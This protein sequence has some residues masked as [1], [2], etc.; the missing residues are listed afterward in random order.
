[1]KNIKSILKIDDRL[2]II[3]GFII[4]FVLL[5][6]FSK[7]DNSYI[8]ESNLYISEI[9][10]KNTFTLEDDLEEYS[11][12]IEIH[13]GYKKKINLLGYHLS[14]S[15]FETNKWSFPEII[16]EPG[17]YLIVYASGKNKCDIEKR[18][19]HTNFKLS[20]KG[21]T[22]TLTDKSGNIINKFMYP[23]LA[24]DLAYGF[25]KNKYTLLDKPSPGKENTAEFTY[26]KITNKDLYIN[27]Y[28]SKNKRMNYDISGY[29]SDFVEL[30]NNSEGELDLGNIFLTDKEDNLQKCKLPN[31]KLG[32]GEYLVIYL[33]DKSKIVNNE[34]YANFKLSSD[35]E[36]LMISNGKDIID[37]VT[38]V[39]LIDNVSYGKVEDK[40]YYFTK[41]T[42]GSANSTLPLE[43]VG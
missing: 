39:S 24:N 26:A 11:D 5:F 21:E 20:S 17:E 23:T 8:K 37:S 12:Y 4:T 33:T 29:Y 28:M 35:D 10:P 31:I 22:I 41:P 19:C 3:F 6:F 15:E 43:K 42:P 27:E 38:L 25:L 40:W 1:M 13:N 14:D 16:L 32:K 7:L 30:Y 9:M 34:V 18:S 2:L 36:K